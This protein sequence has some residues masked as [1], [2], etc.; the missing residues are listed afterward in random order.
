M[1]GFIALLLGIPFP[2]FC[3]MYGEKLRNWAN[4]RFELQ[5]LK[6]DQKNLEKLRKQI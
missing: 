5:Q 4:K 3:Y 1:F 2:I 6:R